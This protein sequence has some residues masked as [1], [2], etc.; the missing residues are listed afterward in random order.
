MR[1]IVGYS[2]SECFNCVRWCVAVMT[3]CF[4]AVVSVAK[5]ME[6][7]ELTRITYSSFEVTYLVVNDTMNTCYIYLPVYVFLICGMMFE[8]YFGALEVIKC[9]S[10]KRWLMSK[11]LTLL[12]YT[13]CYFVVLM[14]INFLLS[15]QLFPYT[16]K[17]SE[18]FVKVQV[19]M[20]QHPRQ[21]IYPP[22]VTLGLFVVSVLCIYL[23]I[24]GMNLCACLLLKREDYGLFLSL[25]FGVV[26]S[27]GLIRGLET[28]KT[29]SVGGF[30]VKNTILLLFVG[31]EVLWS[32][33]LINKK[34]FS[35]D[36][37]G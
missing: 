22:L 35:T 16:D 12:F 10:R 9:G 26:I 20:G 31:I 7:A 36:K 6:L 3:F 37:K 2:I 23:C 33:Y 18:D 21:F 25:V 27:V 8:N 32:M 17:W 14:V 19:M 34:D 11:W 24:G 29:L 1:R 4:V 15:H 5:Y 28:T 13:L 30:I